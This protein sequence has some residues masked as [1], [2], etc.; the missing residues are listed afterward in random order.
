[1]VLATLADSGLV[2][3]TNVPSWAMVSSLKSI[4]LPLISLILIVF[5]SIG[6]I[7]DSMKVRS[8]FVR[9]YLS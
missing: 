1:M 6:L 2:S 5:H 4:K 3:L 9:P 7:M 8:D